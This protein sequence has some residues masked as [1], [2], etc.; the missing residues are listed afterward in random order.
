MIPDRDLEVLQSFNGHRNIAVS[1]YLRLDTPQQRKAAYSEFMQ[2]MQLRLDECGSSP[3]CRKALEEDMEIVGLYIRTNGHRGQA[4][5]AIFSCASEL[6]WRVY[7]LP[8]P[9]PTRV[10]VG[11]KFDVEP[12]R[13][14]IGQAEPT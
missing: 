10:S 13:E 12:L 7:P 2:E 1:A 4:G 8:V 5:L 9:V 11:P 6:F 3:E 14:A